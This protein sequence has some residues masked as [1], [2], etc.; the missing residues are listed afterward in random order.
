[1]ED[2]QTQLINASNN[3]NQ[4]RKNNKTRSKV[5]MQDIMSKPILKRRNQITFA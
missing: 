3:K 4:I 5:E 2:I 1:M